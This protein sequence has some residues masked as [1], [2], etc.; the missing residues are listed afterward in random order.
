MIDHT[1]F[2]VADHP[3]R[4]R[5]LLVTAEYVS[6]LY[7]LENRLDQIG[8][9]TKTI[10]YENVPTD[11]PKHYCK[12]PYKHVIW[13]AVDCGTKLNRMVLVLKHSDELFKEV[14]SSIP[15]FKFGEDAE[16]T[17]PCESL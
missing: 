1:I 16:F 17:N 8:L 3:D 4:E 5:F 10:T 13:I 15:F 11:D 14:N 12:A 6:D 2:H 9:K 7:L